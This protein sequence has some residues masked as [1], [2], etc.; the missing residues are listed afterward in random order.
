MV[1]IKG[2]PS[3]DLEAFRQMTIIFK[4]G[5]GYDSSKLFESVKEWVGVRWKICRLNTN[6]RG[7]VLSIRPTPVLT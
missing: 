6:E 7:I 3:M 4:N 1:L 2:N 5:V